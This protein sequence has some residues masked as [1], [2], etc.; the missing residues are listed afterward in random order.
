M[1]VRCVDATL[2]EIYL[3]GCIDDLAI[4][5]KVQ[6]HRFTYIGVEKIVT[7]HARL[8]GNTG[9]DHNNVGTGQSLAEALI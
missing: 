1:F 3:N 5:T 9:G 2:G 6:H 4:K 8:A 7:G